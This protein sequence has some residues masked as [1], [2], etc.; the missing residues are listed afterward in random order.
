MATYLVGYDLDKPGQDYSDLLARLKKFGTRWHN[1][2]STWFV[3]TNLTHVELRDE[4]A[5][6]LDKND[7]LLV[8]NV[9]GD[10]AAW[11]GFSKEAG[12]WL[13]DNL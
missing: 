8:V 10:A 6:Y 3:K 4:L 12:Q 13:K 11:R 9:T 1:L 2:D 7:K 5:K